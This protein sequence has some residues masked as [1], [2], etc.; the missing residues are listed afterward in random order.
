M[1][2]I[3]KNRFTPAGGSYVQD[4]SGKDIY[5]VKGRWLSFTRKKFVMTMD[6]KLLFMV[7]NKFWRI[8][9]HSAMV[10][11]PKGN[12]VLKAMREISAADSYS[13]TGYEP[14]L[15]VVG[16]VMNYNY[17]ILCGDRVVAKIFRP[18]TFVNATYEVTILDETLTTL[19]IA[20]VIAVNNI[21]RQMR[22]S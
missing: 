19:L 16:Q 21:A 20:L 14:E 13:V 12:M 3:I 9:R 4:L 6:G 15:S 18:I 8:F 11:D 1:D 5:K 7:R 22:H 2:L 10:Y 17:E